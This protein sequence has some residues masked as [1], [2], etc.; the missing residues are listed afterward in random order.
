MVMEPEEK[1]LFFFIINVPTEPVIRVKDIKYFL[2]N[3]NTICTIKNI[4]L[5]Q[6]VLVYLNCKL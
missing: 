3:T 5:I 1:K 6:N 2:F 4:A